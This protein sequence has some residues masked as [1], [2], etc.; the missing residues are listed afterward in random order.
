M[1]LQNMHPDDLLA[2]KQGLTA[3]ST[4]ITAL[5]AAASISSSAPTRALVKSLHRGSDAL[6]MSPAYF[7]TS[8]RD[9]QHSLCSH[10]ACT[11]DSG[12]VVEFAHHDGKVACGERQRP[13]IDGAADLG[14]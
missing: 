7:F 6:E 5:I 4:E 11:G 14:E 12:D 1:T 2:T 8:A 3:V 13:L 9:F 10:H